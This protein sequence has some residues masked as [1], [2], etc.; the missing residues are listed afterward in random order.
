MQRRRFLRLAVGVIGTAQLAL[1]TIMYPDSAPAPA[2][3]KPLER[4]NEETSKSPI[5]ARYAQLHH[6][7]PVNSME[8][9][10][11]AVLEAFGQIEVNGRSKWSA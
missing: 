9:V 3:V 6:G 10:D 1:S 5:W 8:V 11:A 2:R 7:A 4:K